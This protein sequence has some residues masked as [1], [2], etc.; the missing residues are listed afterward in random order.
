MQT[1]VQRYS[2]HKSYS[3]AMVGWTHIPK[4][5]Q[6]K[7]QLLS[8][9]IVSSDC[10]EQIVLFVLCSYNYVNI[11]VY[12]GRHN[13]FQIT[14]LYA[15]YRTKTILCVGLVESL[16]NCLCLCYATFLQQ[17]L[18]F[19]TYIGICLTIYYCSFRNG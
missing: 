3:N 6:I 5:T 14:F 13:D 9:I 10:K 12:T 18:H 11:C 4:K 16:Y 15:V 17:V 2:D 19:I 8:T 7:R 1:T